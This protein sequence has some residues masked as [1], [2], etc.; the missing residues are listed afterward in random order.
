M[1]NEYEGIKCRCNEGVKNGNKFDADCP[2][3]NEEKEK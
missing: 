1:T 3:H 2:V